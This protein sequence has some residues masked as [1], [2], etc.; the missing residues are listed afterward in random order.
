MHFTPKNSKKGGPSPLLH[1]YFIAPHFLEPLSILRSHWRLLLQSLLCPIAHSATLAFL[2]STAKRA[3]PWNKISEFSSSSD[4]S[5]LW[6][7]GKATSPNTEA[8]P[9]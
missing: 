4:T 9:P 3:S 7:Y 2:C 6:G 5:A 1:V 8:M